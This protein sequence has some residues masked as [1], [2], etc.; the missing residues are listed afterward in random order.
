MSF[1]SLL[2]K[3]KNKNAEKLSPSTYH[4]EVYL[5]KKRVPTEKSIY[6]TP[7][8]YNLILKILQNL[9]HK[10]SSTHDNLIP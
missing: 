5:R 6:L 1:V 2:Q 9:K 4:P 8:G 3:L 7:T 10:K